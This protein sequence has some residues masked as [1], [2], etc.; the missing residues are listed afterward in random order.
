MTTIRFRKRGVEIPTQDILPLYETRDYGIGKRDRPAASVRGLSLR[1][2]RFGELTEAD[3]RLDGFESLSDML[4]AFRQIYP[5]LGGR[6]WVT[7][8][9]IRLV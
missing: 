7:V 1:Y 2:Q 8:Y 3:A 5:H 6:D 9:R 4:T